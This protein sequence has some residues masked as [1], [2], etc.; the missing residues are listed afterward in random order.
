MMSFSMSLSPSSISWRAWLGAVAV[1]GVAAFAAGRA[2]QSSSVISPFTVCS[3]ATEAAFPE[4]TSYLSENDAAMNKMMSA[5]VIKPTG[6]VDRDFVSMMT[7]HHQGAV[8]MA[9]AER[10]Y[11]HNKQLRQ[12]AQEIVANQQREI[13][14]M[15]NAVREAIRCRHPLHHRRKSRFRPPAFP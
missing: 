9:N 6:D 2:S 10:K 15:R 12:L 5:M 13:T 4:E 3:T 1:L 7:P 11:R 14:M 8:D